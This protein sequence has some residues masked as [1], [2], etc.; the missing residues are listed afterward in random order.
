MQRILIIEDDEA[1]AAIERDYLEIDGF[2]VETAPDGESGLA[3][4]LTGQFDLVLLDL[5]LPGLDGFAVCR[6][7]RDALD[8]PILMVTARQEDIDKIRGLG[9][10]ADDYIEKP[11]SPSVLVA[12][13]KAHLARYA[14]RTVAH[15][16]VH[17]E[18]IPSRTVRAAH[19]HPARLTPDLARRAVRGYRYAPRHRRRA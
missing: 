15:H 13:V 6:R 7:L 8:I 12:R 11:F 17:G 3:R 14:R 9:L 2:A 4:G 18:R 1:I 5:M 10:G 19:R 16:V